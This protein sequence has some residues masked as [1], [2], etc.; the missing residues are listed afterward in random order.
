MA[1]PASANELSVDARRA[2]AHTIV[3]VTG[4]VTVDSS[5]HLR[6]MLHEAIGAP[7]P[8]GVVIDFTAVEYLDTSAIATL[9][10]GSDAGVEAGL[11]HAIPLTAHVTAAN[12][13]DITQLLPLVDGI[14]PLRG[15]PGRPRANPRSCKATGPTIP[16]R[17]G[18]SSTDAAVG[19]SLPSAGRPAAA[20]SA[21]PAGS[22][23]ARW[24]GCTD[25]VD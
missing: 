23:N 3:L 25:I 22:S 13:H 19:R 6:P 7:P 16:N 10:A 4:R 12:R 5:P 11:P 15:C 14:P 1:A 17:I 24:R 9:L 18:T 8:A 20:G 2:G 21:A